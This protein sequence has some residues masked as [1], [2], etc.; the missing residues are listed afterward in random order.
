MRIFHRQAPAFPLTQVAVFFPRSGASLDPQ[1]RQGLGQLALRMLNRGAGGLSNMAFNTRLEKMGAN[2][3]FGLSSDQASIRLLTL[4]ENLAPALDLMMLAATRPNLD[5]KEFSLQ[6]Q[7]SCSQWVSDREENKR[8]RAQEVFTRTLFENHPAGYSPDG[9]PGGCLAS[10]VEEARG[11]LS[12]I[13][14]RRDMVVGVLSDL[15]REQTAD[16]IEDKLKGLDE[17]DGPATHPW[18]NFVPPPKK[19]R[20]VTIIDQGDTETDEI[21]GGVFSAGEG[22]PDYHLHRVISLVFGGDMNSRLFRVVRGERGYS[23]GASCWFDSTH[24]RTP[25]N[26]PSPFTLYTFPS[27]EHTAD[28]LPL[29]TSLYE[30]L[31]EKG[32]GEDELN[33]AVEN[34]V[35]SHPFLRDTPQKLLA[36]DCDEALYGIPTDDE[37]TNRKKLQAVT[38][39]D[40]GKALKAHHHPGKL[41]LVL[42]GNPA[43]LEP[44]AAALPGVEKVETI[45]Y[46]EP[47]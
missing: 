9:T 11:Q 14:G 31:V 30:E 36:L 2:I 32:I 43:R 41:N 20:R 26:R 29:I 18:E 46:P 37:E 3:G 35:N 44:L 23:Y 45:R 7:E 42:L 5:P 40:L 39:E 22:E 24:G 28:A 34:M 25:R 17:G 16:L 21:I 33:R 38:P 15:P 19:G 4:T 27:V 6:Q 1:S 10:T 13:F 12:L 47:V 8:L